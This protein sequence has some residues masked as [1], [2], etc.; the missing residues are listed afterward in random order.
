VTI[1]TATTVLDL[2]TE[3]PEAAPAILDEL[4]VLLGGYFAALGD[5]GGHGEG[6][7]PE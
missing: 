6:P 5:K 2:A 7:A 1:E 3:R 4:A